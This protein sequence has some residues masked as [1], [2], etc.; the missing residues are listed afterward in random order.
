MGSYGQ[1][2]IFAGSLLAI[3]ALYGVTRWLRLGAKPVL[4]DEAA[5]I[6]AARE[7]EDGFEAERVSISRDGATALARNEAGRIM[8]IKRHGNRF[9]G[10]ILSSQTKVREEV[11]GLVVDPRETQLGSVRLTLSDPAY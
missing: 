8:V 3:F 10:R 1:L 6:E 7:V 5:A 4:A 11:D 2:I 9:A